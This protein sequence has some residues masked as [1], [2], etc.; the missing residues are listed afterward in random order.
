MTLLDTNVV[1][2]VMAPSPS[3]AVLRWLDLQTTEDLYLSA[4]TVAEIAYGLRVLPDGTR[5]RALSERFERFVA[6]GFDQRVLSFDSSAA[7]AYAEIMGHRKE[8]GRPMSVLDGQI[9]AIAR[10]RRMVLATRNTRDFEECGLEVV[11]PFAE[12]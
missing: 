8:V 3:P 9:A 5:R 4:V 2:V 10:S 12:G 6:L 11:N 7:L 1:S